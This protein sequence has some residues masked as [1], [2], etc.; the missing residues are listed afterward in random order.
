MIKSFD[1]N[2]FVVIGFLG[3]IMLKIE[4]LNRKYPYL[5]FE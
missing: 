5:E 1:W 2:I 3:Q 4:R